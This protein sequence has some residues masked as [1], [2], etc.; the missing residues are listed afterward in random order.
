[1]PMERG[2]LWPI[3]CSTLLPLETMAG[4]EIVA[5]K[6]VLQQVRRQIQVSK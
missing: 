6:N 1:M 2:I 5:E 3:L 4:E